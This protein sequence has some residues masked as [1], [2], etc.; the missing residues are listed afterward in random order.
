MTYKRLLLSALGGVIII[1]GPAVVS[2]QRVT[3][4]TSVADT[5]AAHQAVVQKNCISCHNDKLKTAGLSLQNLSVAEAPAQ[6]EIWEKV[7]R[8]VRSGEMPPQ[9]VR[10]RPEP[11]A[12]AALADYL[13]LSLDRAGASNPNPGRA[14]VHRLNRAEYSNAV[15]DLLAVDVRPGDWL[16]VDDSGYGFDNVAAVLSTSPAL[17][18]RYM[19]AARRVSRL[20]VGDLTLKPVEDIYDSKRDPNKGSRNE[21]LSEDLPFDSRAGIAV[22]HYFPVDGEYEFKVR[23]F[24]IQP[25]GEEGET[26]PYL[27]RVPVKAGLHS[28]GVT[29]PRENMKIE[30]ETPGA[31]GGGAGGRGGAIPPLPYP[32]DLRLNGARVKRFDVPG[33]TPEVSK[34]IIGGPYNATG[35]GTTPSRTKIFTCRPGN[36]EP[37]AARGEGAPASERRGAG[38]GA[39]RLNNDEPSC[40]RTI[41]TNLARRA[42]RRPVTPA[43]INPLYRFYEKHRAGADFDAGI[44]RAIEAM[45][46]SPDFLFRIEKDPRGAESG[47]AYRVT[48]VEL[49][50]RLSFFLWSSIPDDELLDLAVRGRLRNAAV[51]QQQVRRMLDDPK[52]DALISNFAG[53]WLQLRNVETAKPDLVIFPFDEALR[54]AFMKETELFVASIVREDRSLMD[55]LTADYT[56]VN[57]RLAEHYGIP[58]VY[59]SQ[60]RRVVLTDRNRHGLLGQGSIL[61]VTSYPNRTSVVQRGKWILENLLGTPPPPPPPDV[62]ELKADRDGKKLSLREQMQVHRSNA[63]CAACHA[64]MDPIGFAL[65]NYDGVGRWRDED[66]GVR[67]DASGTLPDGTEF[68]GPAGL[69]QLM[70]SKYRDDFVRTAIEKL[71]IYALGRGVEHYDNPTIR[72]IARQAARDN[73]RISSLILGIINS[74][75][76]QMRQ[77]ESGTKQVAATTAER[78]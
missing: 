7:L 60:F 37:R 71:M 12:A 42:F 67:I 32:V 58:K 46:V 23:F 40:A 10:T 35:R 77:A 25:T 21:R 41:L 63:V 64:R 9:N 16:P 36:A 50:S 18:E 39:P 27:V 13:E 43:D 8:K 34:L 28:V 69:T 31:R 45:L 52:S 38:V 20:A 73:Y 55:L 44:Q 76:F 54:Q 4:P 65:E 33:G 26:D 6:A 2:G 59:G 1:G 11:A 5:A 75:P 70:V 24:G 48:D 74:T 47:K 15:R 66:A 53:Q 3:P 19:S 22:Q 68:R 49:A 17:L 14:P 51:L 72:A 57:Q 61:T 30:S 62:P 29:S 56:F 78:P